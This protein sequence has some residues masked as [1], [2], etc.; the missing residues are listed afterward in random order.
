MQEEL[1]SLSAKFDDNVLDATNAWEH[2]VADR[3]ACRRARGC[4]RTGPRRTERMA[5]PAFT[6]A[7]AVVHPVMHM[8]TTGACAAMHRAYATLA[9]DLGDDP[10][11]DN[12]AIIERI[13]SLR[14][15]EA[16]CSVTAT[17]P[18][19][20]WCRKW[21]RR[22]TRCWRSCATSARRAPVRGSRLG[23]A[24]H[25]RARRARHIADPQA[26]DL[27]YASEKLRQ[28]RYA[29]SEQ[30][31]KQYFPEDRVLG[32]LFHLVETIY[33][34]DR[35]APAATPG[36]PTCASSRSATMTAR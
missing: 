6:P 17:S 4:R 2:F 3:N 14:Q 8:P 7:R 24:R 31:V 16:S 10:A 34:G 19:C 29:F 25:L 26:W 11:Y 32:G 20:R 18:K 33:G 36:I 22:P 23:R 30:E 13:L 21:R 5:S 9:S 27:P 35:E 1:A 15:E 28:K 12:T